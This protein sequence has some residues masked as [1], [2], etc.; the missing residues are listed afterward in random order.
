[1]TDGQGPRPDLRIDGTGTVHPVGRSASQAL[2]SRAGEWRLVASPAEV[3]LATRAGAAVRTLRFAGQVRNPGGLC[4]LVSLVAQA[5]LGGEL[6]VLTEES[7]RSVFFEGGDVI[8]A[9]TNV[10]GERLGEILWRFGAITRDQLEQVVLEAQ[11]TGKRLGEAAMSLEFVGPD[12]L[13]RMMARQVE[14][15]FYGAAHVGQAT[16]Y[17]FDRFDEAAV[18]RRHRLNTG[19]LL[20]EAARRMDELH[21]FREKIPSDAWVPALLPSW[22]GKKVPPELE[23]VV[24]QCDGR[25]SV[26]EIGRRIGQLE[27]EVTRAVF[28]LINAG[29]VGMTA[30]APEGPA[31]V[32]EAFNM[33]L[34]EI[35]RASDA[36]GAGADLRTGLDRFAASTGVYMPLF[37]GAGPQPDGSLLPDRIARNVAV[38]AGDD[39][40]NWLSQQL[41]EY[42]GFALFQAGSRLGRDD[43]KALAMRVSELLKPVRKLP[44]VASSPPAKTA[45]ALQFLDMMEK[46]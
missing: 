38:L 33:A 10:P 40:C 45:P 30:P 46:A 14:E 22:A 2:R 13:F 32:T 42:L 44:D 25:R 15:V 34:L 35:H 27:F 8:G 16:F 39:A 29:I 21:F 17:L 18:P 37:D 9:T 5:S 12:E 3:V 1:M 7:A 23:A 19:Q 36:V 4:D 26:A 28:Q 20:M 43:E 31:A 24:G 41:S 11:K 6:I